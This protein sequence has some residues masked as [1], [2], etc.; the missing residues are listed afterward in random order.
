MNKKIVL[1]LGLCF[2]LTV[3][4]LHRA[5]DNYGITDAKFKVGVLA[6]ESSSSGADA[7]K[8]VIWEYCHYSGTANPCS[9]YLLFEGIPVSTDLFGD[10]ETWTN[11]AIP[12]MCLE[13]GD[14]E[15]GSKD[16]RP[17][18]YE[19]EWQLMSGGC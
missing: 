14:E 19:W 4:N 16:C 11:Q 8:I 3:I 9:L 5:M 17:I 10:W 6:D 1:G 12:F 18:R 13:G 15:C 2:L 7:N